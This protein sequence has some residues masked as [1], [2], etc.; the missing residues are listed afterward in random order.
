[1]LNIFT[2]I[3][4]LSG[5]MCEDDVDTKEDLDEK[6]TVVRFLWLILEEEKTKFWRKQ[7]NK[8]LEM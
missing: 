6:T 4:K 1:M 5:Q 3:K 8:V 7:N 2:A